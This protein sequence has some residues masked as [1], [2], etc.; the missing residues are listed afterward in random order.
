MRYEMA[1]GAYNLLADWGDGCRW[2]RRAAWTLKSAARSLGPHAMSAM[3]RC[4]A[5]NHFPSQ[6]CLAPQGCSSRMR[7]PAA[8]GYLRESVRAESLADTDTM[9]PLPPPAVVLCCNVALLHA[10]SDMP[11]CTCVPCGGAAH[12]ETSSRHERFAFALSLVVPLC[13][14]S[15]RCSE[16]HMC[17]APAVSGW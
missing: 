14:Q 10:R 11:G 3:R 13:R 16:S 4:L 6:R 5:T 15:A 7:P 9:R 8:L 2:A 1:A 12:H 17:L